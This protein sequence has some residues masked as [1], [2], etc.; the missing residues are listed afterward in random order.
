MSSRR[1][2][3]MPCPYCGNGKAK[4]KRGHGS[5]KCTK[6]GKAWPTSKLYVGNV[7]VQRVMADVQIAIDDAIVGE[8]LA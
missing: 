5:Y 8:G 6:C 1:I 3:R 7:E 2:V 4:Y